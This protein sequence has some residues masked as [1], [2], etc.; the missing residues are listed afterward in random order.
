M[1]LNKLLNSEL[2]IY[3][4]EIKNYGN[5]IIFTHTQVPWNNDSEA[6]FLW[7]NAF[8]SFLLAHN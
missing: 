3:H 5:F 2:Q 8:G 1:T 6:E 7:R 4:R